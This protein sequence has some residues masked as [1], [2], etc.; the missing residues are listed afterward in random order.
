MLIGDA[1]HVQSP[2]TPLKVNKVGH[3][4][5][6]V[7]ALPD[8]STNPAAIAINNAGNN[9]PT[10]PCGAVADDDVALIWLHGQPVTAAQVAGYLNANANALFITELWA[11][12]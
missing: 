9:C 7:A 10:G 6:L 3:F 1:R 8:G 2:I 12:A 4:A 5:D 11:G